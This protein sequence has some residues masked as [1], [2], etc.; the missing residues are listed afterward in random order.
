MAL[1]HGSAFD[2]AYTEDLSIFEIVYTTDICS[3]N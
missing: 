2:L 1:L 3:L